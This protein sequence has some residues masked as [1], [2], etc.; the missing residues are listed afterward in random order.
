YLEVCR[1]VLVDDL[2]VAKSGAVPCFPPHYNIYDR[3]VG[4]Y[5]NCISSRVRSD[6]R[7]CF[8]VMQKA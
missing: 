8:R 7:A 3:F 5:H 2:T 4:M 6:Y 1:L